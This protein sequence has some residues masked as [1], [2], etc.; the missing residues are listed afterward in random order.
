VDDAEPVAP[1]VTYEPRRA[2]KGQKFTYHD[3]NEG[4]V[5][6]T[7]DDDGVVRPSTPAEQ[8]AADA[9]GLPVARKVVAAEKAAAEKAAPS[10]KAD[11]AGREE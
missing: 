6:M 7:A 11:K 10:E 9:F 8:A 5:T 2:D 4:E 3:A 1:E